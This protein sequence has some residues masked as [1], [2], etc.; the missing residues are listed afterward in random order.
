[1]PL[2]SP[3]PTGAIVALYGDLL[4]GWAFDPSHPDQRLVIEAL[5]DGQCVAIARADQWQPPEQRRGD[6]FHGFCVRL[7]PSWLN[8]GRRLSA[9]IAN[10]GPLLE[11][12]VRLAQPA[13]SKSAPPVA[14][15]RFDGGLRVMGWVWD[16]L[17]PERHV[18]VQA[19]KQERCV[20]ETLA[21]QLHPALLNRPTAD[22]GFSLDLPWALADGKPHQIDI[23][24]D[25]GQLL[26]GGQLTVC[27]WP[28]GLTALFRRQ[29]VD[30]SA[31]DPAARDL[32][33]T[34]SRHQD[35]RAPRALGFEHYP[36]WRALYEQPDPL[37]APR[38][39]LAVGVLLYGV[40]DDRAEA[41]S[42]L[43]AEQ[44]RWQPQMIHRV[45]GDAVLPG[46]GQLLAGGCDAVLPLRIGDRLE[47]HAI[48]A[49]VP[50]LQQQP[51]AAEA[52][53]W[54]YADCDRDDGQ[55]GLCDPWLKPTWDFQLF[56]GV[57]LVSSGLLLSAAVLRAAIQR[58][59]ARPP[60]EPAAA[61]Q[62]H[63]TLAA[64]VAVTETDSL[65][66][67]HLP[68]LLYHRAADGP[69]SQVARAEA[70][71]ADARRA[72]LQWLVET[73]APGAQVQPCPRHP[74]LNQVIW[75]L[76]EQLPTVSCLIP[77]RDRV[78]LLR[79][80]IQGLLEQTDYPH[81]E[82]IVIDNGSSCPETLAYLNRVSRLGV[83]V[84]PYPQPF[85][86]STMNNLA[87]SHAT[88]ELVCLLNNDIL[89]R[90]AH[91]LKAMVRELLRPKVGAVGAKLLWPNTMVQH[92]G[93][94]VGING[95]AAHVGNDWSIHD[96]GYLGLNQ[97]ARCYS[98]VTGACLLLRRRDYQEFGGLD[99]VRFPVNFNDV[100]LCLRLR[101]RGLKVVWTPQARLEHLESASRGH[102]AESAQAARARREQHSLRAR[103]GG[104][105]QADP[106]YHPALA[107][108]WASG[109]FGA[110]HVSPL[111]QKP[112][113]MRE[114]LT[115][116][117]T[118][119]SFLG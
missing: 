100:D 85:N 111:S 97:V 92:A 44:Q 98:A 31:T 94:V 29:C 118:Q 3:A 13:A 9:R 54:V 72:A 20:A 8:E 117:F 66:V 84:L 35:W 79:P 95:L 2:D 56:L 65:P 63:L 90:E 106:A 82:I 38:S 88:G 18:T 74:A 119:A 112:R 19:Y 11:G 89:I 104:L 34:L 21:D 53:A 6:G 47:P 109:P 1:M 37:P 60:P 55:G 14:E 75:P 23:Q 49:L 52:A 67:A 26:P 69:R 46:I 30:K 24:T 102:D 68:R 105:E 103:C 93:V 110:L 83:R 17:D 76:P 39:P 107:H 15:L 33:L 78:D 114:N 41:R 28:D 108:D 96:L 59:Q 43:S 16:P 77:T 115:F 57:D 61:S 71:D 99:A 7:Q 62:W 32:I 36:H 73:L 51:Q 40:G 25:Q 64:V 80:C 87:V 70:A 45:P 101:E 42:R 81:L 5:L 22:H 10:G 58:L 27:H 116:N 48:D 91:W 12:S 50:C 113:F 4:F 86:F